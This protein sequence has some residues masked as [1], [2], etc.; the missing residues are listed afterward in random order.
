[1]SVGGHEWASFNRKPCFVCGLRTDQAGRGWRVAPRTKVNRQWEDSGSE[2]GHLRRI[3][4]GSQQMTLG[5]NFLSSNSCFQNDVGLGPAGRWIRWL[6]D[7]LPWNLSTLPKSGIF[8]SDEISGY[9]RSFARMGTEASVWG[10]DSPRQATQ[11][12]CWEC[13]VLRSP[14][15]GAAELGGQT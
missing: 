11:G 4:E 10:A 12:F 2:A 9:L 5:R 1:M 7:A 13:F 8:P 14:T 3:I 15:E 6:W